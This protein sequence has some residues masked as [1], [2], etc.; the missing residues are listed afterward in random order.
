MARDYPDINT[1]LPEVKNALVQGYRSLS[2]GGE[3]T[4]NRSRDYFTGFLNGH[5][6]AR[7]EPAYSGMPH[8]AHTD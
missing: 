8:D 6:S 4:I 3:V 1:D 2:A 5:R 7:T